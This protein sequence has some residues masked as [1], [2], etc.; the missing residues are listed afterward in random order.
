[1]P[2]YRMGLHAKWLTLQGTQCRTLGLLPFPHECAWKPQ[3]TC[4]AWLLLEL[5]SKQLEIY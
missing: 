4:S 1:M 3:E 2:S 5:Q